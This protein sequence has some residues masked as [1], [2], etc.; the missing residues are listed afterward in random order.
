MVARLMAS[1]A[2][3]RGMFCSTTSLDR[4]MS[5]TLATWCSSWA[6]CLLTTFHFD[7][8][9][10]AVCYADTIWLLAGSL[11]SSDT[12]CGVS[13]CQDLESMFGTAGA[14][15]QNSSS[16][17]VPQDSVKLLTKTSTMSSDTSTS[18]ISAQRSNRSYVHLHAKS[19]VSC[20]APQHVA[21]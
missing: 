5:H 7:I 8:V 21:R 12:M 2:A 13:T 11:A 15:A 3:M 10:F 6:L 14:R 17:R 16:R 18:G 1:M 4:V 20:A 9:A 19:L